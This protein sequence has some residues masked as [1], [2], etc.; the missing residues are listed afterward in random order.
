MNDTVNATGIVL[1]SMPMGEYDKRLL[2]LTREFGKIS[3]FA[4]G[5]RRPNS[6]L[7]GAAMLFAC[8][9]FE[10]FEG[11]SAYTVR[12]ARI[13]EHFD[14]LTTDVEAMCYGSYFAEIADFYGQ[15][16]VDA[17]EAVKLLYVALKALR[18]DKLDRRLTR[19]VYELKA[20]QE[21]G[22]YFEKPPREV[23]ESAAKAWQYVL[24]NPAEKL[25]RFGLGEEAYR[26]FAAAVDDLRKRFMDRQFKSLSILEEIRLMTPGEKS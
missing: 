19:R 5:A 20:M 8:G 7:V 18:N 11:R 6:P 21:A 4:K 16:G 13:A 25:F 12:G 17:S 26:E 23:G 9:D 14:Y 10:L 3:A 1:S 22:E 24:A 2:L 15:E